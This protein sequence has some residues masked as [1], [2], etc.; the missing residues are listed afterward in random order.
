M[1]KP[2]S[3]VSESKLR[4]LDTLRAVAALWVF[5]SHLHAPDWQSSSYP[6]LAYAGGK[7]L[8]VL[9]C[10]PAAVIVFFVISGVCI[11]LSTRSSNSL[12]L[13]PFLVRRFVRVGLPLLSAVFIANLLF[14]D[15][16]MLDPVLWS[17]Y[18]ELAY[19][20]LYPGFCWIANRIG[21]SW[22]ISTSLVAAIALALTPDRHDGHFWAYGWTLTWLLGLPSWLVGVHVAQQLGPGWIP[23]RLA[24]VG[25]YLVLGAVGSA[26]LVLHF[27][28]GIHYKLSLLPYG[29]VAGACVLWELRAARKGGTF[30]WLEW[31][32]TWSYSLYLAH[33]LVITALGNSAGYAL[34]LTAGLVASFIFFLCVEAPS[35]HLARWLSRQ[36]PALLLVRSTW[37]AS[38]ANGGV[39][40][41]PESVS[42]HVPE[43]AREGVTL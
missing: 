30:A 3:S 14:G 36:M 20:L 11:H 21:W 7:L 32:G 17:L 41:V 19:Y 42:N 24:R 39:R 4:G 35:H 43:N 28:S 38:G 2:E 6:K 23:Q 5:L 1:D 16:G 29:F 27:H 9:F 13:G 25:L 31:A 12:Q 15:A 8:G 18:C 34:V 40:G 33:M 37:A 10:G 26:A 22:L